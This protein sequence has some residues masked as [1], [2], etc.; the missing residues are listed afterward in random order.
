MRSQ[1]PK[2]DKMAETTYR[3]GELA[4][5]A[6]VTVRTVRYYESLGLLKTQP[7]TDGGQRLYTDADLIYLLRIL[8][9]K[10]F[11][12]S[13]E[14]I[15]TIIRMGAE[16]STGQKRRLELLKQYR[17]QVT[18]VMHRRK[19]LDHLLEELAWHVAQ[20]ESVDTGFQYCPGSACL[21]CEFKDRCDFY[22]AP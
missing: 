13:L 6:R 16:D 9:L 18:I 8:Q 7:R 14:A 11:G 21:D 10:G 5:K 1:A 4:A 19:E 17:N 22:Q 3:I 12:L 2:P 15:G 20:L